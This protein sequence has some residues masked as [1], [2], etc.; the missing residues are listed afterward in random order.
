MNR[1]ITALVL[2]VSILFA[3]ASPLS[4]SATESDTYMVPSLEKYETFM[5]VSYPVLFEK[6]LYLSTLDSCSNLSSF[7]DAASW[8]IGEDLTVKRCTEILANIVTLMNYQLE[9]AIVAQAKVDTTKTLLDYGVNLAGIAAGVIGTDA[10]KKGCDEVMKKITAAIGI[11]NGVLDFTNSTIEDLELLVQLEADYS[12]Q[13]NFLE[14]VYKYAKLP[15]MR[16]AAQSLILANKVIMHHKLET[17]AATGMSFAKFEAH[18]VFLD[19]IAGELLKD[20]DFWDSDVYGPLLI[21]SSVYSK[22]SLFKLTLDIGLFLGD[23]LFGTSDIYNRYNEMVAMRDI[24]QALLSRVKAN[25]ALNE[26]DYENMDRNISLMKMALYV[27]ARGEYC[28]Y[29]MTTEGKL[30]E[31]FSSA[32]Q[33]SIETNY[34]TSIDIIE[35]TFVILNGLYV[36][37]WDNCNLPDIEKAIAETIASGTSEEGF[38]WEL[39]SEGTLTISGEG[40]MN[41]YYSAGDVSVVSWL[42]ANLREYVKQINKVIINPGITRVGRSAFAFGDMVCVEL[43]DTVESIRDDAF[44]C[45]KNLKTIVIPDSVTTIGSAFRQSGLTKITIP[46]NVAHIDRGAFWLCEDLTTITFSGNAPNIGNEF[47]QDIFERIPITA[48]YP[49][50]NPTWTADV[51]QNYGGILTWVPM[52]SL[53]NT[54]PTEESP[55]LFVPVIESLIVECKFDSLSAEKQQECRGIL[56]DLDSDGNKELILRYLDGRNDLIFEVWNIQ[57]GIPCCMNTFNVFSG[58]IGT[59]G[60]LSFATQEGQPYLV[61]QWLNSGMDYVNDLSVIFCLV[62][63]KYERTS[64]VSIS[65]LGKLTPIMRSNY[66][67]DEDEEPEGVIFSELADYFDNA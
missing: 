31:L 48:Y 4:V 39:D 35:N 30:S 36:E 9:D 12:M 8:V 47:G 21:L 41:D 55:S 24:R 60:S 23:S 15:E 18:D 66:G 62:D 20:P 27:D 26:T 40:Q 13:Y 2:V 59:N 67:I 53:G 19:Q 17:I 65:D 50:G 5:D 38:R 37:E 22:Y 25:P 44:L 52:D 57:E 46:S 11:T 29:Q 16:E 51:M 6:R 45:C 61:Y 58:G 56:F 33:E 64:L 63:G 1:R 7:I 43:P 42:D 54:N 14:T 34:N 28:A 10:L 32:N 49:K 3:F